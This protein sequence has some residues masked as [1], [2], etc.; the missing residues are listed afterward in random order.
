MA[1][2]VG[3]V[4]GVGNDGPKN[5]GL[6]RSGLTRR[7]GFRPTGRNRPS[8]G[9]AVRGRLADRCGSPRPAG[10]GSGSSSRHARPPGGM[11]AADFGGRRLRTRFGSA[12][13]RGAGQEAA[14]TRI[15]DRSSTTCWAGPWP[16]WHNEQRTGDSLQRNIESFTVRT[17]FAGIRSSPPSWVEAY[18]LSRRFLGQLP[19][20]ALHGEAYDCA[21][22]RP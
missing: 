9:C 13:R 5:C 20:R 6:R 17:V 3:S 19:A 22:E 4:A 18:S 2:G 16:P 7:R 8:N 10:R 21:S 14:G 1:R 12:G 15:S 11:A